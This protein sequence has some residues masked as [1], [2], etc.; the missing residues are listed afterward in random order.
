MYISNG[1][2]FTKIVTMP[3]KKQN[4]DMQP[5]NNHFSS[6]ETMEHI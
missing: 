4:N 3:H 2:H 6:Q 5:H 1:M